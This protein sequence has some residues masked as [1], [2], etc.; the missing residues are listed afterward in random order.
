MDGRRTDKKEVVEEALRQLEALAQKENVSKD[1]EADKADMREMQQD[2]RQEMILATAMV[3]DRC[4][5]MEGAR[6]HNLQAVGV[7]YGYGSEQE[8]REAGA[9]MI[10]ATVADLQEML[11]R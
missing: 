3:G 1:R 8:L 7:S 11:L 4:Y 9:H 10:A 5:D 2:F 6:E